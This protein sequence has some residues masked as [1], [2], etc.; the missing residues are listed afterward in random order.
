M[1]KHSCS[2]FVA[3]SGFFAC[4]VSIIIILYNIDWKNDNNTNREKNLILYLSALV[5]LFLG[6]AWLGSWSCW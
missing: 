4:I 3:L 1:A 2:N 6:G 5:V